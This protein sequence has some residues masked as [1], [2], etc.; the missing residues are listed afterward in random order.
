MKRRRL[1]G[2]LVATAILAGC[3]PAE[4]NPGTGGAGGSSSSSTA[5]TGGTG[6]AGG[7][8]GAGGGED[9]R[10]DALIAAVEKERM[11]LGAPGAAV[12]V[13]ED[14]E[15]TFARGFGSKDPDADVPVLPTT[16]FRIGSVN[17]ML[18]AAGL[19]VQVSKGT[20]D[21][22]APVTDL[23][24]GFHFNLDASW[25]PTIRGEHLLTHTSGMSDYL[26][27]DAPV[28]QQNDAALLTYMTGG[29][30]NVD[31][32]MVPAGTFYN[33]SN[34]NFYLAGLLAET[35]AVKPY[36][37]LMKEDVLD[38]LGMTRTVFLP[39]EVLADGDY[40]IGKNT[41]FASVPERVL[42]DTYDNAWARPAGYASSSVLD[43]AK[44][45]AFLL[46]G[47]DAVL[48][49]ALVDEMQAPKV[50]TKE[51]VDL[52]HY[53]YG[54]G[55]N[56]GIFLGGP[57]KFYA[58]KV[59]QHGGAIPGFSALVVY[60]P[61]LRFGFVSLASG[62]GAELVDSLVTAMT[63]LAPLPAPSTGPDLT[64]DPA[65]FDAIAGTYQD[66]YNVGTIDVTHVGGALQVSMPAVDDAGIPY[67]ATLEP[68]T[69]DNFLLGIQ[70]T[71]LLVTFV[72]DQDG[73]YRYLRTRVFVGTRPDAPPPPAPP[74]LEGD[75]RARLVEAIRRARP[76]ISERL[77]RPRAR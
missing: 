8:G 23:V 13:I 29:F 67:D 54:L 14:G 44:F 9:P 63:T 25:A 1:L 19:L 68:Y 49:K 26:V 65:T 31:Y 53:A 46:D 28:S 73:I 11:E 10:F 4:E 69:P 38:P 43:L 45:V 55:V 37:Q 39:S 21:L 76:S 70:G 3:G 58:M 52:T 27:I 72:A 71:K 34:P 57:D 15:V 5:A 22:S 12:A 47:D 42:P 2:A 16:L 17:K 35:A 7:S 36:R 24:P 30:A 20:V 66:D 77:L 48:P 32:L 74:A 56:D 6:G 60:A 61:S 50:D 64:V 62:D 51:V 75:R 40:A 59:V 18:T 41:S 33:Y